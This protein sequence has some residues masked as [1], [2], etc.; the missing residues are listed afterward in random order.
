MTALRAPFTTLALR[1]AVFCLA[2]VLGAAAVLGVP[3]LLP[4]LGALALW[5]S[6]A[7]SRQPAPAVAPL[8]LVLLP[9]TVALLI[10]LGAPIG[11][12]MGTVHR[13]LADRLL[14]VHVDAPPPRLSRRIGA[15]VSDGPGW[16]AVGYGL[17][18]V[19]LAIPE[20]YGA[21]CYVFGLVNLSY[22]VWWP[23]FRN[24]PP[25]TRLGPVWALT[26][27]GAIGA[28]TFA[29]AFLIA[30]AG[31]AMLLV[32]PWLLRAGTALDVAAMRWLLGPR[33]LAE[34]VRELQVTR[35]RAIDDAAA[36]MRRLERD[37][38]DG[39]Q[40]RLATLAMNL[41]MAAE[42]LGADGPPPDLA[43]ARELVALAHRG[44]KDALTDLRD[45]VRGIHPPVLDNG[46]GDALATLA[47]SSAVPVAVTVEL[48]GRPAPA[49]ET[50]AYFCASELLANAAKHSRAT[51]VGLGV[52][53]SGAG[54]TLTV[55][56]DGIG[57]ANPEGPGLSGL[58]RRIAVV[59]GRMRVHSPAGGPTRVE[60]D[61]PTHV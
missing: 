24:H 51:R 19:P 4:A 29:G 18:K 7:T 56:D 53:A 11:R 49:I 1:R 48:P 28:R 35:A 10:V 57:G 34:R 42:K 55:T 45:L 16:R 58:A 5:A 6:G 59:D 23:L 50:I 41:G 21:F 54:L 32:A 37:L 25:G 39:A 17:L 15:L 47:T 38:H 44:A 22:P 27:F 2:G 31:L 9:L 40:I 20:G 36:M 12:A 3:V 8:F 26:P 43:Q 14:D 30:A 52:A 33:R 61:L 46:L 13:S 60:I